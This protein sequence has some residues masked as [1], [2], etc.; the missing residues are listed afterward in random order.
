LSQPIK[1]NGDIIAPNI[2]TIPRLDSLIEFLSQINPE[3]MFLVTNGKINEIK[4]L[5]L[6]QAVEQFNA[7]RNESPKVKKAGTAG[8]VLYSDTK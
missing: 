5:P 4:V 1:F 8:K 2:V 3:E 6:F 7:W